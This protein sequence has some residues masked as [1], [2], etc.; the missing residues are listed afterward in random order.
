ML[1][2]CKTQEGYDLLSRCLCTLP[3]ANLQIDI[4]EELIPWEVSL[5]FKRLEAQVQN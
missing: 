5:E 3:M 2:Q 1:I 4:D